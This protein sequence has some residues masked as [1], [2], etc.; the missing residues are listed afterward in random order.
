MKKS[1][2]KGLCSIVPELEEERTDKDSENEI[3]LSWPTGFV[4]YPKQRVIDYRDLKGY[5]PGIPLP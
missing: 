3:D 4:K 2:C 5:T 1:Q